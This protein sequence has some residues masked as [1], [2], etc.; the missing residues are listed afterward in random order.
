MKAGFLNVDWKAEPNFREKVL[1]AIVPLLLIVPFIRTLWLPVEGAINK[2]KADVEMITAQADTIKKMLDVTTK[3]AQSAAASIPVDTKTA[4]RAERILR[5]Q[6]MDRNQEVANVVST[7]S[8]RELAR[9]IT[10]K[11]VAV[12]KEAPF[13]NYSAVPVDIMLEGGYSA[14]E[15]YLRSIE[16]LERPAL[17]RGMS[18]ARGKGEGGLL[19]ARLTLWVYLPGATPPVKK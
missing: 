14:I 4:G 12:G 8:S 5:Y 1:F 9:R 6:T 7:L 15:D 3:E 13:E 11:N 16:Q 19:D 17:L 2:T 18:I 10:I